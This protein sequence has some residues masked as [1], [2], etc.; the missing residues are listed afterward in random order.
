MQAVDKTRGCEMGP[1]RGRLIVD[2]HLLAKGA[3]LCELGWGA[4]WGGAI[5]AVRPRLGFWRVDEACSGP[6]GARWDRISFFAE[7]VSGKVAVGFVK[8]EK[9]Q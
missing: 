3:R 6:T 2:A 4:G 5:L 7:W 8:P 1:A 9:E